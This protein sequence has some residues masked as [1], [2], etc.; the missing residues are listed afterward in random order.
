MKKEEAGL[1]AVRPPLSCAYISS[2]V[3]AA[4][5]PQDKAYKKNKL[6]TQS[7]PPILAAHSRS[8]FRLRE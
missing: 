1:L 5:L 8:V 2:P 4:V 3:P 7:V 6:Q